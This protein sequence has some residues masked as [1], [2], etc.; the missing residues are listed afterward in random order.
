MQAIIDSEGGGFEL[1]P[2]DWW[3]YAEKVRKAKYDLD[4]NELRPYFELNNVRDGV[5]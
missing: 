5:F 1:A 4:D 2:W 3:Y